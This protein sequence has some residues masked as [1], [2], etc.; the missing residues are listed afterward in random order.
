MTLPEVWPYFATL[1]GEETTVIGG[2]A[3][4]FAFATL[5]SAGVLWWIFHCT[6][7]QRLTTRDKEKAR[8]EEQLALE[9]LSAEIEISRLK[10]RL[11]A[12]ASEEKAGR[13]E[14]RGQL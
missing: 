5:L 4:A 6:Y 10:G 7:K 11:D 2:A 1:T 13:I 9:R 14:T 3:V 8:L 12:R